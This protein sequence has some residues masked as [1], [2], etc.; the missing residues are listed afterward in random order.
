MTHTRS[1]TF[2]VV[3]IGAGVLGAWS[4]FFLIQQGVKT[5]LIDA[6]EPG[7]LRASSGGE[8]RVIRCGYGTRRLYTRW[9]WR[10][11]AQW[12]QWQQAWNVKL[13]HRIGVLWLHPAEND[14]TRASLAALAE[15]Q[16]PVEIISPNEL[17]RRF[18]QIDGAGIGLAYLEPEAGVLL[19]R[20]AVQAV[21]EAF[22]RGGGAWRLAGAEA[23]REAPGA[24]RL[25]SIQLSDGSSV[26]AAAFVFACGPWL[27]SLFP[28]LLGSFL[29][30]TRQEEFYFGPPPGDDRFH[31]TGLPAWLAGDY[32]GIPAI[33][34]RG[35]KVGADAF[36]PP[37]DP[38]TGDRTASVEGAAQAR[39]FLARR[40]PGLRDAPLLEA[41]VC[42]YCATAD[43]HLLLD[44]HPAWD[45]VWLVG[46]GSG[47]AF[48][49]G[50]VVGELT[51]SLVTGSPSPATPLPQ[52]LRLRPRT[53]A[54]TGHSAL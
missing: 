53:E 45:N 44:R 49:L 14:Y 18:P 37:F 28:E 29:R 19:A 38:T 26:T 51:A 22:R 10:A 27:P 39:D 43:G 34:G 25:E 11:L 4:A 15:E 17:P 48:K 47:H 2:D 30:V 16:I 36:G 1:D 12:K 20:Q 6:W 8:A 23:P 33:A 3:V 41:R 52:E 42:Q 7:H 54:P 46:G 35:F 13:F 21:V 32:Y 5:L 50:P 40:F 31:A 24:R 9:A